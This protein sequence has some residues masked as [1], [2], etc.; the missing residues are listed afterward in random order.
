MKKKFSILILSILTL[1][2]IPNVSANLLQNGDF[3]NIH[4]IPSY[5]CCVNYV[6]GCGGN[7][8]INR[9]PDIW[10]VTTYDMYSAT[11]TSDSYT[12]SWAVK[13]WTHK[14]DNCTYIS[15]STCGQN[16]IT[17]EGHLEQ[18][19][20]NLQNTTLTLSYK[21][22][23]C[24]ES[25]RPFKCQ[26][27]WNVNNDYGDLPITGK[28]AIM[29]I[30]SNSNTT[31]FN[32][33]FDTATDNFTEHILDISNMNYI[34]ITAPFNLTIIFSSIPESYYG[35][36]RQGCIILDDVNL[37]YSKPP[38]TLLS[39][40]Y[41][42]DMI[43]TKTLSATLLNWIGN[44]YQNDFIFNLSRGFDGVPIGKTEHSVFIS[45]GSLNHFDE[46]VNYAYI[47]YKNDTR[48]NITD[49][50]KIEVNI[51][52]PYYP[53]YIFTFPISDY[54][55]IKNITI[56]GKVNIG[57][58]SAYT[59]SSSTITFD[60]DEEYFY[61]RHTWDNMIEEEDYETLIGNEF[62]YPLIM[63]NNTV[64]ETTQCFTVYNFL[65]NTEYTTNNFKM[66]QYSSSDTLKEIYKS[67]LT[68][69]SGYS[70]HC[71]DWLTDP[72]KTDYVKMYVY[73][74]M[75]K[76]PP[77]DGWSS[78]STTIFYLTESLYCSSYCN[79]TTY[80]EGTLTS[81]NICSYTIYYND[82]RCIEIPPPTPEEEE[83]YNATQPLINATQTLGLYLS[84][85]WEG[86]D[87]SFDSTM[88]LFFSLIIVTMIAL[89]VGV[90]LSWQLSAILVLLSVIVLTVIN[91]IPSWV[92]II[93]T[94]ISGFIVVHLLRETFFKGG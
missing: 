57:T 25:E 40:Q 14:L 35:D 53:H 94:L 10:N 19:V 13:I 66:E 41:I 22:K 48:L 76:N 51:P 38:E 12:G 7:T 2:F 73:S 89:Y 70:Q 56:S 29:F 91:W 93:F 43:N 33:F 18:T 81:Q 21:I 86:I 62:L 45:G 30:F 28:Y 23:K 78:N 71:I 75:S 58:P 88:K 90:K 63:F 50:T 11:S 34:N 84:T 24:P 64:N 16:N 46:K 8:I 80:Y 36:N 54:E 39:E 55:N 52:I 1:L 59:G 49:Y 20:Y 44:P 61:I 32:Y 17:E 82:S 47:Y 42:N 3:E 15:Y 6:L 79:G 74:D 68:I 69:P 27:I 72:Q 9:M 26:E 37:E 67:Q 31:Q 92:G 4:N 87:N 60:P 5:V 83:I 77:Q 65:P 85:L